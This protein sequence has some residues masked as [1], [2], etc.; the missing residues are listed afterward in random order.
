M[1]SGCRSCSDRLFHS[2]GLAVAQRL[3]NWLRDL[4]TKHVQI[5]SRPQ[6]TA[7]SGGNQPTF[8]SQVHRSG[9]S[10]RMG[11]ITCGLAAN[12]ADVGLA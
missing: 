10:Q 3:P 11:W 7:A 12:A 1:M 6:R 9:A 8:I 2:V 4:L 5:V